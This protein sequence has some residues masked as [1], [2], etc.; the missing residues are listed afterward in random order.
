MSSLVSSRISQ[1]VVNVLFEEKKKTFLYLKTQ[2]LYD[3]CFV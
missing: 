2:F 3:N 1:A